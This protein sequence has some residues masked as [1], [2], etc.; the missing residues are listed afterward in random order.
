MLSDLS[1]HYIKKLEARFWGRVSKGDPDKC[2]VW[3]AAVDSCGYGRI[4]V[5]GPHQ[6]ASRVAYA[7]TRGDIPDGMC[8]CH[9]CDNPACVNPNHLFLGNH[10]QN[11]R[12]M[13]RKGRSTRGARNNQSVL[14]ESDVIEIRS[15][16]I[17]NQYGCRR[18]AKEYG[19]HTTTIH[20]I[21]TGKNWSHL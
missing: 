17:P 15:K 19:V 10:S 21:V 6:K 11:M 7:L 5:N 1:A 8:V 4:R 14:S 2:W 9:R 3:Q 20:L 12:D 13:V 18:L 16:Y